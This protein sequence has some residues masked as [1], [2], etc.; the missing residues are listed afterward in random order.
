[1]K[2]FV[3]YVSYIVNIIIIIGPF[4]YIYESSLGQK[5]PTIA[6][7]VQYYQEQ[8]ITDG[9]NK[10]YLSHVKQ[11]EKWC[12][13]NK[14]LPY[15]P[16]EQ[17][18]IFYSAF[19]A[20]KVLYSTIKGDLYAI[21]W[22]SIANG[23]NIDLKQMHRLK[24]TLKGIR[25]SQGYVQ[26]DE[27]LPVTFD[28]L[29]KFSKHV[30]FDNFDELV[31]FTAMVVATFGLLRTG[32]FAVDNKTNLDPE[33]T[34]YL[35]NIKPIR[36]SSNQTKYFILK[37]KASKTD[38]FRQGVDVTIGHGYGDIDPVNL[39][40][41]MI[42]KRIQLTKNRKV[43]SKLRIEPNNLLFCLR[44]GKPVSR[45]DIKTKLEQLC[46]KC[47]LDATRYK[48]HSFRIGGATSLARR[49]IP[50]HIIQVL[51]RWKSDCYK[52]YT[53]YSHDWLAALQQGVAKR[54]IIHPNKIFLYESEA[55]NNPLNIQV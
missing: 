49:G 32:E 23:Y 14:I 15:P 4:A 55:A 33:K 11:Y 53:R 50:S 1:M 34:L 40:L 41:K 21:R 3:V 9:S 12:K 30:N 20:E 29:K 36:N 22:Y 27:R 2:K 54:D 28:I 39:I 17:Q 47:E 31:V 38:I 16:S 24:T 45:Y 43:F 42:S 26:P 18:L 8:S 51:G 48:G 35:K 37:L 46:I 10:N 44:N 13:N 5:L 25:K 6:K 19:R 7:R 52:I